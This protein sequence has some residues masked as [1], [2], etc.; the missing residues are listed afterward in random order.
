MNLIKALK[1]EDLNKDERFCD[2]KNRMKNLNA[3][4]EI[5]NIEISKKTSKEWLTIFEKEGLPC[6]PINSIL[7]MHIDSQTIHRKMIIDVEN[8]KAGK[9]KAIGMPIK[10][11]KSKTEKSKGAPDLGE[12]TR[13]VM[14]TFGYKDEDIDEFYN[15]K[16]I[17]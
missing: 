15:K 3:L 13:E 9:S 8:K 14:K 17:L 11:S 16:I 2:N 4:V 1:R 12:H 5:L 7:D 10:F 6:G